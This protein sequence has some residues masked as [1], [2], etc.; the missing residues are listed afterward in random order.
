METRIW[1]ILQGSNPWVIGNSMDLTSLLITFVVAGGGAY[2]GSYLRKKGEN[3]A[4]H[5]DID[6]L[7][8]QVSAVTQVTKGIESK[9]SIDAWSRQQRWEVQKA[10]L[11]ETLKELASAEAALWRMVWAFSN[12]NKGTPEGQQQLKEASENFDNAIG[13]FWRT[14]LAT[15]IVCGNQIGIHLNAI[16]RLFA[17]VRLNARNGNFETVWSSQFDD[18]RAAMQALGE[19]IRR[20]LE[21]GPELGALRLPPTGS[22]AA[23][24]LD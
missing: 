4:T 13:V 16:D 18:I 24:S 12:K 3:L 7:I 19:Q 2:L 20:D 6:K 10:A 23:P 15:S 17:S 8:G 14:K 9:I 5:E 11:L 21:F 1:Q 22:S